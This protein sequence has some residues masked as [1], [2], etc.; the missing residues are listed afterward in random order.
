MKGCIAKSLALLLLFGCGAQLSTSGD[1]TASPDLASVLDT[2]SPGDGAE[3]Q[4]D[5]VFSEDAPL[6]QPDLDPPNDADIA[7]PDLIGADVTDPADMPDGGDLTAP[8]DALGGACPLFGSAQKQGEVTDPGL[9]EISGL[10]ITIAAPNTI[11]VHN[12]S[13]DAPRLYALSTSGTL[14]ATFLLKGAQARDWEDMDQGPGPAPGKNYFYMGDIGDNNRQRTA[15]QIYRILEPSVPS[16]PNTTPIEVSAEVFTLT[17]PEGVARNAEALLV[18]PWSGD[19]LVIS[20]DT[21]AAEVFLKS[22]PHVA[23]STTELKAVGTVSIGP[24][25]TAGTVSHDGKFVLLKTYSELRIWP[26][27]PGTALHEAFANTPCK[28]PYI[29]EPQGE[30]VGFLPG[31]GYLTISEKV[32]ALAPGLY[33]YP[34]L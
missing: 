22:A 17:Y 14:L 9:N 18:D 12:D 26:R 5:G 24:L 15:I 19:L 13:G 23:N 25:V 16:I 2:S 28:A 34:P 33:L 10:A 32:G 31:G 8:K 6:P 3:P 27:L 20:K 1:L 30:A 7:E 29:T 21:G 11:W 4:E